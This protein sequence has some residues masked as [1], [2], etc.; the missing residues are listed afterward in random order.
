MVRDFAL[1]S[2]ARDGCRSL[3]PIVVHLHDT[4]AS[5]VSITLSAMGQRLKSSVRAQRVQSC[6]S[7]PTS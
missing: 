5:A 6:P 4:L 2:C 3:Y 7:L 1:R